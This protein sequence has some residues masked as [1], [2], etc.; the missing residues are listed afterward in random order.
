MNHIK[1]C[2]PEHAKSIG[3]CKLFGLPILEFSKEDL[4]TYISVLHEKLDEAD[5][6]KNK[7]DNEFMQYLLKEAR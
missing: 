7:I 3:E 2:Y 6:Q 5:K 1:N 4:A